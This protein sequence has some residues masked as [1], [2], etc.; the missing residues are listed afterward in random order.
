MVAEDI[1]VGGAFAAAIVF[2]VLYLRRPPAQLAQNPRKGWWTRENTA[3]GDA[4]LGGCLF[5]SVC[6]LIV[7]WIILR[8]VTWAVAS[9]F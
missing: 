2:G 4:A 7:A 1:A 6:V 8:L 5:A 3:K 9:V